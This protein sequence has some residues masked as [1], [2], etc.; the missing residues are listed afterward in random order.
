[1]PSLFAIHNLKPG[2][3]QYA[4]GDRGFSGLLQNVAPILPNL[5]TRRKK[6]GEKIKRIKVKRKGYKDCSSAHTYVFLSVFPT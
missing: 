6:K 1:M 5:G 3:L 4:T 2:R